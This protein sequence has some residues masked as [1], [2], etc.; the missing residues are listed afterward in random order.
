MPAFAKKFGST[1]GV[2]LSDIWTVDDFKM[3]ANKLL[4][5]TSADVLPELAA[6]VLLFPDTNL[7]NIQG[8][9]VPSCPNDLPSLPN[10]RENVR[11]KTQRHTQLFR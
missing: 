10:K 6:L 8:M 1:G 3:A 2:N 11:G 4:F 9:T 7:G 5:I